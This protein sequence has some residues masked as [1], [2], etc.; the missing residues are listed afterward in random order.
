MMGDD[1][2]GFKTSKMKKGGW[3][4]PHPPFFVF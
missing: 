1:N 4:I 3:K 2:F